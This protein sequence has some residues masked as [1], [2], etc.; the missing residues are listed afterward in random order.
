[1]DTVLQLRI[2]TDNSMTS[3]ESDIIELLQKS[4]LVK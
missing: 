4:E 3:S 2:D 1:M